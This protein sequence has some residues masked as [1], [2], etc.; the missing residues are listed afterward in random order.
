MGYSSSFHPPGWSLPPTHGTIKTYHSQQPFET[1][2]SDVIESPVAEA[3]NSWM[4]DLAPDGGKKERGSTA[5]APLSYSS[6]TY[7]HQ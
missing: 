2:K 5:S 6:R 1:E 7:A 3:N 4:L